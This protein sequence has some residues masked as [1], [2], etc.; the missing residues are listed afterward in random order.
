MTKMFVV[1]AVAAA[2]M[3]GG[4]GSDPTN[5]AGPRPPKVFV[6]WDETGA[7]NTVP[8]FKHELATVIERVAVVP[9]EV[10][11][12]V[13]DGQPI[14]TANITTSNFAEPLPEGKKPESI[15]IKARAEGFVYNLM[16][17]LSQRETVRGS[18]QL[19]GLRVAANTPGVTEIVMFSDGIVNEPE[20]GFDLSTA[21]AQELEH[22]ISRWKPLLAGLRGKSVTIAGVGRGVH[23]VATVERAERLFQALVEGNGARLVWTPTLAQR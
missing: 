1:A 23:W 7:T 12:A 6:E 22:E 17:T 19:Q 15:Y 2:L 10:L 9:G 3:C 8:T 18:G 5:H 16:K 11:A 14:T 21:S 4:C 13:I 20:G